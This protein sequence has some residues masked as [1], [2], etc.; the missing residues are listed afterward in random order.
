MKLLHTIGRLFRRDDDLPKQSLGRIVRNNARILGKVF[1]NGPEYLLCILLNAVR[2]GI[3]GSAEAIYT[4]RLFDALDAGASFREAAVIIGIMAAWLTVNTVLSRLHW[5]ILMP[6]TKQ[7]LDLRLHAELFRKARSIDVACYDDPEFYNDF[8][9]AMDEAGARSE[10]VIG[11]LGNILASLISFSTLFTL[12]LSIDTPIALLLLVSS[13]IQVAINQTEH[14]LYFRKMKEAKPLSRVEQYVSRVF[15]L[16][17]YTKEIRISRVSDLLIEDLEENTEKQVEVATRYGKKEFWLY[18]VVDN[19]LSRGVYFGVLLYMFFR[20]VSGDVLVG[21][22]AASISV[23]WRVQWNMTDFVQKITKFPKH[24]LFLEKYFGFLAYEPKIVSGKEPLPPVET[25]ELRDVSFRYDFSAHPKYE[26]HDANWEKPEGETEGR[27]GY[28]LRH[29]NLTLHKGEKIA[30]VGYNG[31]GKTTLLKTA[32]GVYLANE[33]DILFDGESIYDNAKRKAHLFYVPDDLYFQP[34]ASMNK[35]AAFYNGYYPDFSFETFKELTGVFGLDPA[36]PINGFSKGMQRQAELVLGMAT[37]PGYL[38]LDES[39]DGLDP[40]K[41]VM[42]KN[43][44]VEYTKERNAHVIISSH[45]LHDLGDMCDRFGLINGKHLVIDHD[46]KDIGEDYAKFR[47]AF[48][49]GDDRPDEAF[50]EFDLN[51]I[52]RDGRLITL[53]VKGRSE[54]AEARLRAMGPVYI[55]KFPL[56]IEEIFMEEVEGVDY[57]FSQIF[58]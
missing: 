13:L 15:Q 12:I 16:P 37:N 41:R 36:K 1:K 52:S 29:V 48:A 10:E 42:I 53:I 56:S 21:A 9:W 49:E 57:D 7:K 35:M 46:M 33:G 11:D 28:A 5:I 23:V 38:L 34:Y 30:I 31:A 43:L 20:L 6:W 4:V 3:A 32:A 27:G 54:E 44:V 26:Y 25:L 51:G 22:F 39:F 17:D 2:N 55:E 8:V 50:S 58:K 45:N 24:S 14:R 19:L 47:L 18:G 40:Q